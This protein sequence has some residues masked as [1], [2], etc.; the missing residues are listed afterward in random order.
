MNAD[1]RS[2]TLTRVLLAALGTSIALRVFLLPVA[3]NDFWWALASGR[4][5]AENGAIPNAD[6][7][8]YTYPGAPWF[9]QPWLSQ[10]LMFLAH[11]LGG[12]PLVLV[13]VLAA[14]TIAFVLLYRL[15]VRMTGAPRATAAFLLLTLPASSPA[16]SV[17]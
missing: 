15:G 11:D 10:L 3:P 7:F 16:W 9:D 1:H 6:V 8:S 17:R 4:L 5:I 2:S 13:A 14:V 12:M